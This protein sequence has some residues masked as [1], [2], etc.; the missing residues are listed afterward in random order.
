MPVRALL[1]SHSLPFLG[2][3]PANVDTDGPEDELSEAAFLDLD[4]DV[5]FQALKQA[6][7]RHQKALKMLGELCG[8]GVD[9]QRRSRNLLFLRT[10]M[11]RL[12]RAV[13]YPYLRRARRWEGRDEIFFCDRASRKKN[14]VVL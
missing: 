12:C 13:G 11:V 6:A 1:T 4:I 5:Q 8:G 14:H 3:N 9:V 7:R 2:D 10:L